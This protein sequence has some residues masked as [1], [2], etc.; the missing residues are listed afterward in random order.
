MQ[1]VSG[2]VTTTYHTVGGNLMEEVSSDGKTLVYLLDENGDKYGVIYNGTYYYY[3][4]NL[5]G[6]VIGIYNSSGTIVAR[7][8]YD[9]WG[10]TIAVTNANGNTITD[11]SHIANQNPIRYRGY[12]YDNETGFYYLQSRYYD[13]E[14]GRWINPEPNVDIGSFDDGAGLLAYNVYAYCANN[15]VNFYDPTGEFILTV[16]IGG[17]AIWKIGVAVVAVATVYFAAEHTKNKR[18]STSDKHTKPRPGRRSEKKKQCPKWKPRNP[19]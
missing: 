18:K 11:P 2:G 16:T 13:P 15:P 1:K 12:Y 5:Q 19:K 4:F 7:Y 17:I 8:I 9:A 6:D 14:A 3:F 10:K